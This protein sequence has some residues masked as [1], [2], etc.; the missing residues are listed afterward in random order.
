MILNS[1]GTKNLC[2]LVHRMRQVTIFY[3]VRYWSLQ[4]YSNMCMYQGHQYPVWDIDMGNQDVYFVSGSMDGTARLWTTDRVQPLR[5]FA[6]HLSDVDCVK[7]HHNLN[8]VLTGSSDRTCRLWDNLNGESVRL[9]TGHEGPITA[10]EYSPDGRLF[11]CAS[12]HTIYV[13]DIAECKIL[14]KCQG[15]KDIIT[16]L[17]FD[18]AGSLLTSGSIDGSVCIW[19]MNISSG[20]ALTLPL[21]ILYTKATPLLNLMFTKRNLLMAV[22]SFCPEL[23]KY[24]K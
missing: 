2:F 9:F 21:K 15:H 5:I 11:A 4:N 23:L 12:H 24:D 1:A 10:L 16:T 13:W 6:G 3:V 19:D 7:L 17:A 8:Y 22:G 18:R 20:N 14:T